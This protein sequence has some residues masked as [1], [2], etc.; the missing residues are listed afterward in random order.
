MGKAVLPLSAAK[1]KVMIGLLSIAALVLSILIENEIASF[2]AVS[3]C[4]IS[5]LVIL[6]K[7]LPQLS[8]ISEENPKTKTLRTITV[9]NIILVVGCLLF[10]VL[11]EKGMIQLSDAQSSWLFSGLFAL[12]MIG[13]GNA[14]PKIP[15]NRYTGL[16]LPWTVSDEETWIVAHRILGYVSFPCGLLCFA[17][18]GNLK[19]TVH[20]SLAMFFTWILIPAVLSYIFFYKK[21]HPR[22]PS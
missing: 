2:L 11:A 10:A 7:H 1:S 20:I 9:V 5:S 15:F 21:W 22:N 16:R 13:F 17:G 19:T 14:A 4:A 6:Y 8:N 12:I 3:I 18:V